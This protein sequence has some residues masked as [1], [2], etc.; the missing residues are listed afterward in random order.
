M[1]ILAS[2]SSSFFGIASTWSYLHSMFM[3]LSLQLSRQLRRQH[4]WYGWVGLVRTRKIYSLCSQLCQWLCVCNHHKMY[5]LV[6]FIAVLFF[7][8]GNLKLFPF[9]QSGNC[10]ITNKTTRGTTTTAFDHL[11]WLLEVLTRNRIPA[12]WDQ[13]QWTDTPAHIHT[14]SR[15]YPLVVTCSNDTVYRKDFKPKQ[16]MEN[17]A[18]I[19]NGSCIATEFEFPL[20]KIWVIYDVIL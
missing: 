12:I 17:F 5:I 3:Y 9:L 1:L 8:F 20:V 4:V 6:V 15:K 13:R 18:E 11:P 10:W 16:K 14:L 19:L 7:F 2:P